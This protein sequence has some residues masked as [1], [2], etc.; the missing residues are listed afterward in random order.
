MPI[1][2]LGIANPSANTDTVLAGFNAEYLVSVVVAN[3]AVV[4]TPVTRVSIWIVPGGATIPAQYAYIAFNLELGV[5]SSFET[6]RFGVVNGDTVYVRSST[7]NTS[8][9]INGILQD[10]AQIA[11]NISETFTNKTI[12]GEENTLLLDKGTT[13]E[14]PTGIEAGYTRFNTESNSL[15]VYTTGGQWEVVG[16]GAGTA[17]P[18]G[19]TG[20]AGDEGPTGPTGPTGA[21]GDTGPTGEA[22]PTGP[23]GETGAQGVSISLLGSVATVGDLPSSGNTVNDAYIVDADG[24]L[25][26]W[27]GS[28][29]NDVGQIQ[30]PTGP[31]GADGVAGDTGPTGPTGPAGDAG[32]TGA[33]GPT[34]PAGD[35]GPTGATGPTGPQGEQGPAINAIAALDV[36]NNSSSAYQ[37]NSHYSGDNPT[38]YAFGGATLGFDL[39]NVSSSHPFQIQEDSGG[40]F[41]NITTGIIHVADDGTVTEGSGAQGQTSGIVY[42]EVPITSASSWQYICSVHSAMAGT[43]TIKSMSTL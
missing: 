33:T 13:S 3:K 29:W 22:G 31:T 2:R 39:T 7:D 28:A 1:S 21:Q 34:G 42:W 26:V 11:R 6:F 23:T 8:F 41:A 30:G 36:S 14:R 38:V 9:S 5:G 40:G 43:L 4:A 17:G 32:P 37:F 15:E 35:A 25:Y 24:N 19:P 20:P 27:D 12:R 10:D 18:T 16:T